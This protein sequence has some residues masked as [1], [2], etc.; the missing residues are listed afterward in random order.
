V[1]TLIHCWRE[2]KPVDRALISFFLVLNGL[3]VIFHG[4]LPRWP[5][6]LTKHFLICFLILV[7][8][9]LIQSRKTRCAHFTRQWYPV[10]SIPFIYWNMAYFIHLVFPGEFDPLIISAETAIFGV[11]PNIPVQKLVTPVLTEVMQVFYATYWFMI[12]SGA[13]LLYFGNREDTYDSYLYYMTLTFF[14]SCLVFILFPVAGP[15]FFIVDQILAEYRGLFITGFLRRFV[16]DAGLRGCAFPSA[17]VAVAVVVMSFVRIEYP[18]LA[19]R[20]FLPLVVGLSLATIYGQYHYLTDVAAGLAL[21]VVV[22]MIGV[23]NVR[24]MLQRDEK[25]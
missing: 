2:L 23:R 11:L 6:H 13:A 12:P 8:V 22:S 9:P 5:W 25:G 24:K 21:G 14:A 20:V 19:G 7:L 1:K 4:N 18:R 3:I 10:V 15:R 17:H 16:E